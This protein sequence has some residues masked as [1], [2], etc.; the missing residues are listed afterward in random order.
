MVYLCYLQ[1]KSEY[2]YLALT[3]LYIPLVV[4]EVDQLMIMTSF[5]F[6]FIFW[7]SVGSVWNVLMCIHQAD[8]HYFT[9]QNG[10]SLLQPFCYFPVSVGEMHIQVHQSN[11][12]SSSMLSHY[13][14]PKHQ[15]I[16]LVFSMDNKK[17]NM[18]THTHD[19]LY[20]CLHLYDYGFI[21][22]TSF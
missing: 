10:L 21:S 4:M 22:D 12:Q 15:W 20:Y 6:L 16:R 9:K 7:V 18:P 17:V 14:L 13:Q 2:N 3:W 5:H 11:G 19:G 8:C 1:I